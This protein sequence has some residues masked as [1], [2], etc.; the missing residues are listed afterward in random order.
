MANIASREDIL[1]VKDDD[2]LFIQDVEDLSEGPTGKSKKSKAKELKK[3]SL[4]MVG[5]VKV[6]AGTLLTVP[7]KPIVNLVT[8]SAGSAGVELP[9]EY[10][11]PLIISSSPTT[12][13]PIMDSV[14][15][16][17]SIYDTTNNTFL[18]NRMLGQWHTWRIV[19]NWVKPSNTGKKFDV[20]IVLSNTLSS[21]KLFKRSYLSEE[22]SSGNL[23]A[24]FNTIAD[25]VSLPAPLGTGQ[26]YALSA[27]IIGD[28]GSFLDVTLDSITRRCEANSLTI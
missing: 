10:S 3:Y 15:D 16:E 2:L 28:S 5:Q 22:T 6:N 9:F 7:T 21:F 14:Q 25:N 19:F 4:D 12:V 13:Y 20:I 11:S 1:L 18:E 24:I 27:Y 23:T 17:T 26:G 8:T